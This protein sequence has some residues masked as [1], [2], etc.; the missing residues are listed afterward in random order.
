M[1]ES[2]VVV[3]GDQPPVRL[4]RVADRARVLVCDETSLPELLPAADVLLVWDF[5]SDAVRDAWPGEGRR[6]AWVH[7]ASAGVDRLLC[8]ELIASDTVLTNARGVFEQPIAEYVAGLVIAMA[9]DLHGSWELQRQRRWQHRETMRL[10]GTRAVVVGAGPIGRAIGSTLGALGVVVDLV[11][12]TARQGV[13]GGDELPELLPRADWVVCAAP[14]TDAT[15]GMFD[16]SAFDRMKPTARFIN[17][18]RGPLVVEKD[19]T[20]ALV[21]RRIGGAALDVFEHEPL[22]ADDP[23]WDVPGLFVS[24]HMSGDTVG[25]RDHLAEQFQDNYDRW[26]AGEP[27]LNVVDKRLGY[28]PVD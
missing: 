20:A 2:T 6:P 4:D 18:G 9:K 15:R 24:P 21:A 11:G 14:L 5:T 13:R 17:V 8:P 1:S 22:T 10:A 7:T 28:V 23:L 19:L 12:R 3:F 27:L 25:W 26:C 16:R